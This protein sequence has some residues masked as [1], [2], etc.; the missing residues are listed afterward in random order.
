M[1][2]V[3]T[4]NDGNVLDAWT[5]SKNP[6]DSEAEIIVPITGLGKDMLADEINRAAKLGE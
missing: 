2:L 5:V 6:D 4:D 1:H 3:L